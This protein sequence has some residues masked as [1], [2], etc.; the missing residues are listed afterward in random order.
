[1]THSLKIFTLI[2]LLVVVAIIAILAALLLPAMQGARDKAK[3]MVC[4]GSLKQLGEC[5]VYYANDNGDYLPNDDAVSNVRWTNAAVFPYLETKSGSLL[6]CPQNAVYPSQ[7]L[8]GYYKANDFDRLNRRTS[9]GFNYAYLGFNGTCYR[10]ASVNNNALVYSDNRVEDAYSLNRL[11]VTY[12]Q[13]L[14][15]WYIVGNR[16]KGRTNTLFID[17][18]VKSFLY[19]EL[20]TVQSYWTRD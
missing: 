19:N 12:N 4:A 3:E 8:D 7:E 13:P 5:V 10:L 14:D 1:M 9:Y 18:H 16:H 15:S 6:A 11:R 20:N 17:V 2:E